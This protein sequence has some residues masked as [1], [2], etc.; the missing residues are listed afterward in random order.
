MK[1]LF[2]VALALFPIKTIAWGHHG[3]YII[4]EATQKALTQPTL[5]AILPLL[6]NGSLG[7]SSTWADAVKYSDEYAWTRPLHY[8]DNEDDPPHV[9]KISKTLPKDTRAVDLFHGLQNFT[10]GLKTTNNTA[11]RKFYLYMTTHLIQDMH[12]PLHLSGKARGGNDHK[13]HFPKLHRD[14]SLHEYFD[15]HV[16]NLLIKEKFNGKASNL[17]DFLSTSTMRTSATTCPDSDWWGYSKEI[18]K[19]NCG[20]VWKTPVDEWYHEESLIKVKELLIKATFSLKC[21][22]ENNFGGQL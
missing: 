17:I 13:V 7:A 12:Q 22:I 19:V 18:E 9:C 8:Y 14:V 10:E 21:Y 15:V 4:G 6:V 2:L 16:I 20:L 3:H 11:Q 1:P 5:D